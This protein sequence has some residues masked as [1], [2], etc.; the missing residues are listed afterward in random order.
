METVKWILQIGWV[1]SK[2]KEGTE[3]IQERIAINTTV[4]RKHNISEKQKIS[5]TIK[6][7]FRKTRKT[8]HKYGV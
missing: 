4:G 5:Q 1:L 6:R 3:V 7:A 2:E 8:G